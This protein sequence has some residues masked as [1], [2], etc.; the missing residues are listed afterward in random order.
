MKPVTVTWDDSATANGWVEQSSTL[1]PV[2]C[3]TIGF[4]AHKTKRHV[5]V[6]GTL[7][8]NGQMCSLISIPRCA[9][10]RMD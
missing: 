9:I 6:A 10:V 8:D 7:G 5:V 2:R 1:R 3:T 4:L